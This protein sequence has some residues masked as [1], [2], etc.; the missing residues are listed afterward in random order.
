MN[1]LVVRAVV[2]RVD[3]RL[4]TPTISPLVLRGAL[5]VV[6]AASAAI[7]AQ[8]GDPSGSLRA[9]PELAHLLRGMAVLKGLMVVAAIALLSWRFGHPIPRPVA[10]A[11]VASAAL[12]AASATMIWQLTALLPAAAAF[13]AGL[14]VALMVAWRGDD[15][16]PVRSTIFR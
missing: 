12:M 8:L 1:T 16:R 6:C 4:A 7:A 9:D 11:Y 2:D 5:I 3:T 14:F 10:T 15:D 13:H